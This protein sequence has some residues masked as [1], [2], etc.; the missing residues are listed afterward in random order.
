MVASKGRAARLGERAL[1][2][3]DPGAASAV[4]ILTAMALTFCGGGA[5]QTRIVRDQSPRAGR[6][7]GR[8]FKTDSDRDAADDAPKSL[9]AQVG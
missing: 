2:H 6:F 4:V 1:G 9:S 3:L 8:R 7:P 5:Q